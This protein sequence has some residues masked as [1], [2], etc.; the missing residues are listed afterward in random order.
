[1]CLRLC[2]VHAEHIDFCSDKCHKCSE[3]VQCPTVISSPDLMAQVHQNDRSYLRELSGLTFSALHKNLTQWA[4]T[5]RTFKKPQ[6][7]GW[8][9]AQDNTVRAWLE[10][11]GM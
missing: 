9:L 6:I 2:M 3:N 5:R 1:M 8:E 10:T 7:G 4:V 11:R